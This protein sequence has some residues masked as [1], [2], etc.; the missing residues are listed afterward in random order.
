MK[1]SGTRTSDDSGKQKALNNDDDAGDEK[2][3]E[4]AKEQIIDE[5]K[6][7]LEFWRGINRG[8]E[9]SNLVSQQYFATTKSSRAKIKNSL[10]RAYN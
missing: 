9:A 5:E 4:S 2:T 6:K 1:R 8:V 7:F 3:Y 10:V